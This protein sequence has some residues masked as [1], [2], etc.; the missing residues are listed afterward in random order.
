MEEFGGE[1][2]GCNTKGIKEVGDCTRELFGRPHDV[3]IQSYQDGL[4]TP[5]NII[6]M[7]LLQASTVTLKVGYYYPYFKEGKKNH[8]ILDK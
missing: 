7:A 4:M 2:Q 5:L 1:P 6:Y 8:R 3:N